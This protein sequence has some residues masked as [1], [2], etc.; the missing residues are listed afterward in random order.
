MDG[1]FTEKLLPLA[2]ACLGVEANNG[3]IPRHLRLE[4]DDTD[5]AM[6]DGA[7]DEEEEVAPPKK[8]AQAKKVSSN[9]S[10]N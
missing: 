6:D 1:K 3:I 8:K 5:D 7:S 10:S 2:K 4:G 9:R